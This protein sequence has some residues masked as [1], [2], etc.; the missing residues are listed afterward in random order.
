MILDKYKSEI[1][2]LTAKAF[3]NL[4]QDDDINSANIPSL[5]F[6]QIYNM[7]ETPRNPEMGQFALALFQIAKKAGLNPNNLNQILVKAQ[8]AQL[9]KRKINYISFS[10]AG[11]FN[12]AKI[13]TG[14]LAKYTLSEI[15]EKK[16]KYGS[17]DLGGG[18]NIVFDFSSPNIAKP[19]GVGHLRSTAIGNSL[20]RVYDKL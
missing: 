11:G 13:N 20:Y 12:N 10:A 8:T 16:N 4:Y 9:E 19:F 1:A 15:L 7:L 6:E 18:E 2:K 3:V 17:S 5:D 14:T